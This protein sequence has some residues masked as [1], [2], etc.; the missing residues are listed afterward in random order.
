[1]NNLGGVMEYKIQLLWD[2]EAE[3]QDHAR[4]FITVHGRG[5]KEPRLAVGLSVIDAN[6]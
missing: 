5:V 4:H 6:T 2:N 1:M 3:H